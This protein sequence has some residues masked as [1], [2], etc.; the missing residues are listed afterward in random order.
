MRHFHLLYVDEHCEQLSGLFEVEATNLNFE[1]LYCSS[2]DEGPDTFKD[3]VSIINAIRIDIHAIYSM[4]KFLALMDY[5]LNNKIYAPIFL[6]ADDRITDFEAMVAGMK[7]GAFGCILKENLDVLPT[8]QM[9]LNAAIGLNDERKAKNQIHSMSSL[10]A[11]PFIL[12][13]DSNRAEKIYRAVLGYKHVSVASQSSP[14]DHVDFIS[15]CIEWH[16]YFISKIGLAG[17]S[18][19]CKLKF[20]DF[21]TGASRGSDSQ[22]QRGDQSSPLRYPNI[23]RR[24]RQESVACPAARTRNRKCFEHRQ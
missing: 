17:D 1:I 14:E 10:E 9:I 19:T 7:A 2:L 8:F 23:S 13:Q 11:P 6:L 12:Y 21:P 16:K 5:A 22:P 3:Y 24:S 15:G 18:C 4:E 20:I